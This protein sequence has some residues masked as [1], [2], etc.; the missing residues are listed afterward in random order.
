MGYVR[1]GR[2]QTTSLNHPGE[3][4]G[5]ALSAHFQPISTTHFPL[6]LRLRRSRKA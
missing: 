5:G 6:T 3:W 1:A 4:P 2:C